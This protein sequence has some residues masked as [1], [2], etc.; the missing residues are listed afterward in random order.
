MV[1]VS[2]N[3]ASRKYTRREQMGRVAWA[4][5]WPA[6]ALSPRPFWGW[7]RFLLRGFGAKIGQDV[8]I[9]PSVRIIIP[10]NLEIGDQTAVGDRA[11][12]YSLGKITLGNRVT[13]SQGAHLC[14]G[15]HDWRKPDRPLTKPP[16]TIE[17]DVW[18]CADAF[19]GPGVSVGQGVI[20]G[21]RSVVMKSVV[22]FHVVVG[23]PA[24]VLKQI[25]TDL[26]TV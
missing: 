3:R 4:F 25:A 8:H 23:N 7:R 14:A 17:D 16:I 20:V 22:E 13:I 19:I 18:V 10:W 6:F 21:A 9:Y 26:N 12:L 11:I 5:V 1:D 15:S 24:Q 2:A